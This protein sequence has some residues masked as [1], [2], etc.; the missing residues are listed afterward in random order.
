MLQVT[1]HL[2]DFTMK[3][4]NVYPFQSEL[5]LKEVYIPEKRKEIYIQASDLHTAY[6]MAVDIA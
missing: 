1:C 5:T 4:L 2:H 6:G 3:I